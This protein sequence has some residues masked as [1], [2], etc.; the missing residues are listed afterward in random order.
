M[1]PH[2]KMEKMT[3]DAKR[4]TAY[5]FVEPVEKKAGVKYGEP[6]A[7]YLPGSLGFAVKRT[8]RIADRNM[9]RQIRHIAVSAMPLRR[10]A[11]LPNNDV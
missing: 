5:E 4:F 7:R 10:L 8:R 11:Y 3:D 9:F 1:V 2:G 6:H